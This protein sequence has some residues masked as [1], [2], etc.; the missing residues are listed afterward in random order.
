MK[1]R[2]LILEYRSDFNEY[3]TPAKEEAATVSNVDFTHP[4]I[5]EQLSGIHKRLDQLAMFV[6]MPLT[7]QIDAAVMTLFPARKNNVKRQSKNA[8]S[9]TIGLEQFRDRFAMVRFKALKP[10][11]G[12]EDDILRGMIIDDDG[13]VE[14]ECDIRYNVLH[15]WT[16]LPITEKSSHLIATVPLSDGAPIW[17][18]ETVEF[19]PPG[20]AQG[21]AEITDELYRESIDVENRL[22]P[23]E[24]QMK[25][26]IVNQC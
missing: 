9:Y 6:G 14:C 21:V 8:V 2:N 20:I 26:K 16:R 3:V 22:I 7:V 23:L 15:P 13:N 18:P 5:D 1:N 12:D 4:T 19:L 24:R 10:I 17:L 25:N 11:F